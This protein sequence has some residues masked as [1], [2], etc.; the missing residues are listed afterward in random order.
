MGKKLTLMAT[1]QIAITMKVTWKENKKNV[2]K[3]ES[4]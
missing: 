1:T 4:K 2:N 3:L